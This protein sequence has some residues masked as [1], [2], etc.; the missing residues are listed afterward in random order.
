MSNKHEDSERPK[1][2]I[3]KTKKKDSI[4]KHTKME[5][6]FD[7]LDYFFKDSYT[8]NITFSVNFTLSINFGELLMAD[9]SSLY[10]QRQIISKYTKQK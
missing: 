2:K 4:K 3:G 5:G 8:L 10:K 9:F 1:A 6:F 7:Y